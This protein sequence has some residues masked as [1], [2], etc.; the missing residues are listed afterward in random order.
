[1][2]TLHCLQDTA[3]KI[4]MSAGG[5]TTQLTCCMMLPH[6]ELA[7]CTHEI[8]NLNLQARFVLW[9]HFNQRN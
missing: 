8:I 7:Q 9:L 4:Q 2:T 3:V 1:M 5:Y 6:T